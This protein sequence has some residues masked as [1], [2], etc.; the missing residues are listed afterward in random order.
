M[1]YL[2]ASFMKKILITFLFTVVSLFAFEELT[3]DNFQSKIKGKNVIIDFY[4][5]WCPP[6]KVLNKKL[7]E[8][9]IIKS[10]NISIYK[11]N[12]DEQLSLAK[13]YNI[14]KLP[15]LVYFKDGKA[16]QTIVGI[17]SAVELQKSSR[18]IFELE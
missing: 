12:I 10:D 7:Q 16:I 9:D 14:T 13:K 8:F 4:A 18:K 11:V 15:S 1:I 5:V 17:Q 2:K 6:C 3:T